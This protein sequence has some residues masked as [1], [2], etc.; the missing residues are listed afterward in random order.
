MTDKGLI[1]R[2]LQNESGTTAIEYALIGTII[3]V[4][5]VAT[6]AVMGNTLIN[7]FGAGAG[8]ASDAIANQVTKIP[9]A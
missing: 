1:G 8:G 7:L 9:G 3:A 5:L 2:F 6:F 4:A